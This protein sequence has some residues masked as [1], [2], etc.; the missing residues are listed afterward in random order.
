[1]RS[2]NRKAPHASLPLLAPL[3]WLLVA[4]G[5]PPNPPP[6]GGGVLTVNGTVT[7]PSAHGLDLSMLT[8][9]TPLGTYPVSATGA[10]TVSVFGGAVTEL[11]VET[12]DGALLLLG[13]TDGAGATVSLTS[14]AEALL[15]YLVGGMWLPPAQQDK[16]RSLL[17]GVPEAADLAAEL[18]RQ[19]S[20][21]E[22]GVAEPDA[23]VLAALEAAHASLLG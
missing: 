20:A 12:A 17:R 8:V 1:M 16:V 23:G 5:G 19:L 18:G 21:G 10:F 7:L 4:C 13:V 14:T 15:Y 9:S 11:G 3:L 2:S 22:N 6:T